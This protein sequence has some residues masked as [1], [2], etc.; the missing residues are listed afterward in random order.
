[1]E[2][3]PDPG[4]SVAPVDLPGGRR[5]LGRWGSEVAVW[6]WGNV[7]EMEMTKTRMVEM[8]R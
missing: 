1:V 3:S 8:L 7:N 6:E 5:I 2:G 4:P